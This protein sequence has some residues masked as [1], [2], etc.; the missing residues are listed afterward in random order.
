MKPSEAISLPVRGSYKPLH[1][2]L[3]QGAH[4]FPGLAV[5]AKG[6]DSGVDKAI[7]VK[8]ADH[9]AEPPLGERSGLLHLAQ[10]A[11]GFVGLVCGDLACPFGQEPVASLE[12]KP[13]LC[14]EGIDKL[15]GLV[16][17]Q[18]AFGDIHLL[19]AEVAGGFFGDADSLCKKL[20]GFPGIAGLAGGV[21][22]DLP[23]D[24]ASERA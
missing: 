22:S 24:Y 10:A 16:H 2:P 11:V 20:D 8:E 13:L 1:N 7:E 19:F 6:D 5:P 23:W 3:R 12:R 4:N 21:S 14:G 18:A 15:D 9:V 17:F